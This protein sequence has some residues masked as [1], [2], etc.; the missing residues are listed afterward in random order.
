MKKSSITPSAPH[1][2]FEDIKKVDENGVEYWEA[3]ELMPLLGYID[4]KNFIKVIDKAK[5]SCKK[6]RQSV[7]YHFSDISKMIIIAKGSAKEAKRKIKRAINHLRSRGY[8]VE[9]MLDDDQR[10]G[11]LTAETSI[12]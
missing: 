12:F 10:I 7:N 8:Q 2:N 3:R 9:T 5:V 11:Y 4:W 6:S 1:K